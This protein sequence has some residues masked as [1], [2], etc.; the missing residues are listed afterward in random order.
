MKFNGIKTLLAAFASLALIMSCEEDTT[1][2]YGNV[3]MG[4]MV[5]GT[6]ISDQGNIFNVVEQTCKGDLSE[7]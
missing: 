6:F 5:E 1:L 7:H 4:N 3:T 2:R